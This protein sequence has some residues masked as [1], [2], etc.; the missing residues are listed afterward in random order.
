[1]QRY[2]FDE[3]GGEIPECPECMKGP[4]YHTRQ[5]GISDSSPS[6]EPVPS[7]GE[8][9][10][11]SDEGEEH[12]PEVTSTGRDSSQL[13]EIATLQEF[14]SYHGLDPYL[15]VDEY[16]PVPT[17]NMVDIFCRCKGCG[18][19]DRLSPLYWIPGRPYNQVCQKHYDEMK[20]LNEKETKL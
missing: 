12:V 17:E 2:Y 15:S 11:R 4:E 18:E 20:N 8:I 1:M 19:P 3:S 6:S 16:V 9:S 14:L 10:G 7:A 13:S 5:S